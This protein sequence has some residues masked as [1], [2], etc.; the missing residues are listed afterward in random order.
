MRLH[1]HPLVVYHVARLSFE[2]PGDGIDLHKLHKSKPTRRPVR[3]PFNVHAI[4]LTKL[5]EMTGN[6]VLCCALSQAAD[7][8][9]IALIIGF[10]QLCCCWGIFVLVT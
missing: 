9:D 3:Q 2:D 4:H 1:G 5:R 7:E 8:Y 10:F 6:F